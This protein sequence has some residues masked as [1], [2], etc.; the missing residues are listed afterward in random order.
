M[1]TRRPMAGD[2]QLTTSSRTALGLRRYRSFVF[3]NARWDD[4]PLRSDDILVATPT[5]TGTTWLQTICVML[6]LGP[7]PWGRPLSDISPWLEMN[8]EPIA[9]VRSRLDA[10]THRRVIKSHTPL[11]GLPTRSG[12]RYLI[13][14]RDP[15]DVALSS[16]SHVNN[17][18][19]AQTAHARLTAVG[20]DDLPELGIDPAEPPVF[21][22]D[23]VESFRQYLDSDELALDSGSLLGFAHTMTQAW[24]ARDRDDIKLLHYADLR[25]D[26]PG[27]IREIARFLGIDLSA[28]RLASLVEAAGFDAMRSRASDFVPA[29]HT[30]IWQDTTAFFARGRLGGWR[31]LPTDVLDHYEERATELLPDDLRRWLER[32]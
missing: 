5:K 12:V 26:L 18:D 7:P 1:T 27:Q 32:S 23:P 28:A 6:V 31:D 14:G 10:Q 25:A 20:A 24:E 30:G 15:R 11:D 3:D 8:L 4:T 9:D 17:L 21:P 16:H 19:L 2:Q 29:V 13:I 22:D